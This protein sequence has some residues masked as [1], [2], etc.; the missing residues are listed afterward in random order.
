MIF[1]KADLNITKLSEYY[2]KQYEE[3]VP[4]LTDETTTSEFVAN[5]FLCAVM[6][7]SFLISSTTNPILFWINWQSDKR[8]KL[9]IVL[10]MMLAVSD[11]LTNI[12]K[13]LR[14]ADNMLT[15]E[16]LPV[17]RNGTRLEQAESVSFLMASFSSMILT[18]F[19]AVCRF[20]SVRLPFLEIPSKLVLG[21]FI[22][23]MVSYLAYVWLIVVGFGENRM[24][25]GKLLWFL[26][27]QLIF[28][29]KEAGYR[30]KWFYFKTG[31][32]A[33]ITFVGVVFSAWTI[34]LLVKKKTVDTGKS[35]QKRLRS[36]YAVVIMNIGNIITSVIIIL[37][38]IYQSRIPIINFLGACGCYIILSAVNPL[39]RIYFSSGNRE[40]ISDMA[41]DSLKFGHSSINRVMSKYRSNK[42][43]VTE[44]GASPMSE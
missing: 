32:P 38:Q 7:A 29:Y 1:G 39:V 14:V 6:I 40:K 30:T 22:A 21:V 35:S 9:S 31:M 3:L 34:I 11:F 18:T 20:F 10:F 17:L 28:S 2:Q 27:C 16:T 23:C 15:S 36:A 41:S 43:E 44:D 13:P 8:R 42:T 5:Y 24:E 19:I 12:S 37:Y 4:N 26:H 25:S 33:T